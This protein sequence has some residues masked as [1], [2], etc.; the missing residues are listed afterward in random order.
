MVHGDE[1]SEK[2]L[3]NQPEEKEKSDCSYIKTL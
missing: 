3:T 2:R 1:F